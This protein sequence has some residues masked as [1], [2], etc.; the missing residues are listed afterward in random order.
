ME[1]I[2]K[3][4]VYELMVN[5]EKRKGFDVEG[6]KQFIEFKK[7]QYSIMNIDVTKIDPTEPIMP[8]IAKAL[9]DLVAELE[10]ACDKELDLLPEEDESEPEVKEVRPQP[11]PEPQPK[12]KEDEVVEASLH[13][14]EDESEITL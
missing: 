13:D 14:E 1:N 2:P 7:Y 8:Y 6:L 5:N 10:Y 4:P 12:S 11:K 3:V 9:M